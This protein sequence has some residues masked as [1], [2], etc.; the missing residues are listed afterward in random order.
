MHVNSSRGASACFWTQPFAP[1]LSC[2]LFVGLAALPALLC[3]APP[4]QYPKWGSFA[5]D[6]PYE[7]DSFDALVGDRMSSVVAGQSPFAYPKYVAHP[8]ENC[9]NNDAV[10]GLTGP[11]DGLICSEAKTSV[12]CLIPGVDPP[13]Y[14]TYCQGG[15]DQRACPK[16]YAWNGSQ[17]VLDNTHD[18]E[19]ECHSCSR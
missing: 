2:A 5:Y 9:D 3:A 4:I 10:T 14:W 11:D 8:G 16:G 12:A 15:S 19:K 18:P 17:C 6:V 13:Y 1:R 7:F